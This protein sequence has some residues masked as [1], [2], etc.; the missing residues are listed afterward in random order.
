MTDMMECSECGE[1]T[2]EEVFEDVFKCYACGEYIDPDEDMYPI[3]EKI[4]K[5]RPRYQKEEDDE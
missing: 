5:K 3:V 1:N 2:V 4:P